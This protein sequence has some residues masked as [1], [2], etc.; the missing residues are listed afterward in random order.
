MAEQL[1]SDVKPLPIIKDN[2]QILEEEKEIVEEP[3][4]TGGEVVSGS[5]AEEFFKAERIET[6]VLPDKEIIEEIKQPDELS[7][8]GGEVEEVSTWDKL[9]Y[10]WDKNNMVFGN[11]LD[12]GKAKIQDLF[13]PDKS[14]KDYILQNAAQ[15]REEFEKEH[16]MMLEGDYDGAYTVIGEAA[17]FL[18]DPY[19]IAGY[20]FGSA[21]L[22]N[23]L[24]SMAL[25]AGLLGG[26]SIIEDIATKGEVDWGKAGK[27]AAIGG[28]IGLVFP[29]G[30]KLLSKYMP[31]ALEGK[32]KQIE[33]WIDDKIAQTHGLSKSE[34][35]Q[36]RKIGDTKSVKKVTKELD[37]LVA[38][39]TWKSS[40]SNFYAPIQNAKDKLY[41]LR[42]K[43]AKDYLDAKKAKSLLSKELKIPQAITTLA[44]RPLGS[45]PAKI[46]ALKSYSKKIIDSKLKIKEA[47]KAFEIQ[48]KKL[49]KR[50]HERQAKYYN[51]ESKRALKI[52]EQIKATDTFG[53]KALKAIMANVTKPLIGGAGGAAANV[54]GGLMGMDIEDDM[55]E[56]VFAG[57]FLGLT[58]K[59]IQASSKFSLGDKKLYGKLIDNHA[60][61][62]SF[63]KLREL[64]SATAATKLNA[65]GGVTRKISR[66]LFR[67]I[68]DPLTT[69][70]AMA[71]AESLQMYFLRKA[72]LMLKESSGLQQIAAV[73][74]TRGNTQLAKDVA[75]RTDGARILKLATDMKAWFAELKTLYNKAGFYS[76]KELDN[77]FP[78]VLNW[79]RINADRDYA[80]KVFTDIFKKNYKISNDKA[81]KAAK[82]YLERSEGPGFSSVINAKTWNKIIEGT[83]RGV[84]REGDDL[85][86]TP[87]SDH[88]TKQRMLQGEY[89][90]V[91][92]ILEKEGFLIN[93]VSVIFPKIVRDSVKSIAF[94]RTFGRGGELLR[95]LLEQIK[96]KYDDLALT[97]NKLGFR[98]PWKQ[99]TRYSAAKH[100]ASL[101]LDSIDAYFERFGIKNIDSFRS[102]IGLLTMLSNLNMLGRVTISS[103]GDLIQ[104]FQNSRSWTAA[105]KGLGR[106]NL[107]KAKWEKGLARNLGYDF[108]NEMNRAVTV[109][110]AGADKA[111]LMNHS[112]IG[113]WGVKDLGRTD[114]YNT[115]AFKG[116]GLEWLTGYARRFAYNAGSA[117]AFNLSRNYFKVVNGAK[118][119]N[120]RA[121]AVLRRD[122]F[123]T[124]GLTANQA[125]TIGAS[126]NF[127][128]AIKNKISKRFLNKAGLQ[129]S[130]RDALIPQAEN[131]LLFVQSKDPRI[132]M[133]GQFLSWAQAK[134]AQTNKILMRIENG[135]ART[136]IK[137][138]AIIPIY[139][140]IQMLRD[141]AKHG[142]VITD[143]EYNTGELLAKSWQLSGIPGWLSDMVFNRFVGPGSKSGP[144]YV[145][146]PALNMAKSLFQ[147]LPT[148]LIQGKG[149][150]AW[151]ILDKKIL[152]FPE[153]RGWVRQFWSPKTP[154][155]QKSTSS[156]K[157]AFALGGMV[158]RK[159]Y[160]VG[161]AVYGSNAEINEIRKDVAEAAAME[162]INLNQQEDMNK[163]DLASIAAAAAI[164]ATGVDAD[165]NK[166]VE[167]NILPPPIEEEQIS[168]E[169]EQILP[170]EKPVYAEESF[171][172]YIK[173]VENAPLM[174]GTTNEMRHKSWEG[175][176]DTIGFG[177]K[178]T[179]KEIE[180]N[181]V[182]GYSLDNLTPKIVKIILLQDLAQASADLELKYGKQY[183]DLDTKRKQMMIDFQ[184]NM[185]S[186]KF[187]SDEKWTKFKEGMWADDKDKIKEESDRGF[188][189]TKG[190]YFKLDERNQDF[191]NYFFP[192]DN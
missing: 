137:T 150:E 84:A 83:E 70:S 138:L 187:L 177:H 85:V 28:G 26:D 119:V 49:I 115:L 131:R 126:K 181:K 53:T 142:E 88:I 41:A 153:W 62:F 38:Q 15:E 148:A 183:L 175:G 63:Q 188:Y 107:F 67:Q 143:A 159:K 74:I 10:G 68:D 32:T 31:K 157:S 25:N 166:A 156:F 116:L 76:P 102:S 114:F 111:L 174:K 128:T 134:S 121:A 120:S 30:G 152:P 163:K 192:V 87:I 73:S 8:T 91:E 146:A 169:E 46:E 54:G 12:I 45:T 130:N 106:T 112:W 18:L 35:K 40:G 61:R 44:K 6:E 7:F 22:T 139:S 21:L 124:Y 94:S 37:D 162:D 160:N 100:E 185:G 9:E 165:I 161:D 158:R 149:K 64:T 97:K 2:S 96:Q 98:G 79:E 93:D 39:D 125:L 82:N 122:L 4:F 13:D 52:L 33:S 155:I 42:S 110:A 29:L 20:Y 176:N 3:I 75:K 168:I 90:N 11:I 24:T 182:Y 48:H 109:A 118:G 123:E 65:F 95:P 58:A 55:A 132:R 104:P 167:N 1:F 171:L 147:D 71:E 184:F 189:D 154:T 136:L 14:F 173:K 135:D 23:P 113:K 191:K 27:T 56:W 108:T 81:S 190:D 101:V 151:K 69:K 5:E 19:Y 34:L 105:I 51:L 57:M 99:A 80:Q 72:N 172:N 180:T 92:A 89:K 60:V 16:W 47:K 129:G 78:R 86:Y 133:L 17:T 170:E 77:Y 178:L 186:D 66:M 43:L 141:M 144:F 103:L 36:F 164:T 50:Q 140:G 179:D 117:D 127:N 145:F 59:R